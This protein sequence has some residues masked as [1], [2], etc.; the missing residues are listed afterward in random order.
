MPGLVEAL[1]Q[2]DN[3]AGP[4]C[5]EEIFSPRMDALFRAFADVFTGACIFDW[6]HLSVWL[7]RF[8]NAKQWSQG[9]DSYRP[10]IRESLPN[11]M[12]KHKNAIADVYGGYAADVWPEIVALA[13]A[14]HSTTLSWLRL[15]CSTATIILVCLA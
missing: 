10:G 3:N 7:N 8:P 2:N 11:D 15:S 12:E 13:G 1:P 14:T 4:G 5:L 6:N 9:N